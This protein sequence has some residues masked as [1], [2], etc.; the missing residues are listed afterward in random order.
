MIDR[1]RS[2]EVG[3]ALYTEKCCKAAKQIMDA[4]KEDTLL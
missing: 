1:G 2:A 3:S 4:V